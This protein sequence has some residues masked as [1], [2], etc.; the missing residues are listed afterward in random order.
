MLATLRFLTG[1]TS[2]ATVPLAIAWI[3]DN[4]PFE[5][6]QKSIA[7]YMSGII[8]G[9]MLGSALGGVLSDRFGWRAI[10]V[11]FGA[12]TA[13]VA[14]LVWSRVRSEVLA[15]APRSPLRQAGQRYVE[16]LR[17]PR[18][19]DVLTSGLVE[20]F[21]VFGALAYVGALLHG[22][23]GLSF[24]LVGLALLAYGVGGLVYA[25]SA[26]A[27]LRHLGQRGMIAFGGVIM[28]WSLVVIGC[29]PSVAPCVVALGVLG[30]GFYLMHSTLQT[31]ATE[32]APSARGTSFGLFAFALFAG[33]ALGVTA[34]GWLVDREG[35][36]LAIGLAGL[37]VGLLGLWMQGSPVVP[38]R[39]RR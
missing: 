11:V 19:A 39:Q 7:R 13:L 8:F 2:A 20:G 33:Q 34:I 12:A 17:N 15:L 32:M 25:A 35:Y 18:V 21:C 27:I 37:G 1:V 4:V 22:R 5:H 24:T 30:F 10:F 3:G 23:H 6:R 31:L 16:L 29:S 38:R 9:Q 28:A 36:T 14:I 26:P